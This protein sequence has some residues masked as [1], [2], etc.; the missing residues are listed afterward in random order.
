MTAAV[1]YRRKVE[2]LVLVHVTPGVGIYTHRYLT[3]RSK[4]SHLLDELVFVFVLLDAMFTLN[5]P[6][7]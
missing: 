2:A 1:K 3:I 6:T 7:L 5:L 4:P